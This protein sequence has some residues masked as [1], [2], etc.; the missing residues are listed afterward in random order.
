MRITDLPQELQDRLNRREGGGGRPPKYPQ[1]EKLEIGS[2]IEL[3]GKI[4]FD[5]WFKMRQAA[6]QYGSR[7]GKKFKSKWVTWREERAERFAEEG[8]E[9]TNSDNKPRGFIWRVS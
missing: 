7:T 3:S 2:Y 8:R 5:N 1:I 4:E 6:H 9:L